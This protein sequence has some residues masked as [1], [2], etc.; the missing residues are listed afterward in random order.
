MSNEETL[1][2]ILN[3]ALDEIDNPIIE[4]EIKTEKSSSFDTI[5]L[6]GN[7]IKGI[8]SMIKNLTK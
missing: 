7:S 8:V 6:S 2:N 4:N 3:E 5:V 1:T